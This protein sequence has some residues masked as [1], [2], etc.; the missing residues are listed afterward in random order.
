M[1]DK[2]GGRSFV[3]GSHLCLS[4]FMNQNGLVHLD[5]SGSA[6]TR[7]NGR[8]GK[9]FIEERIDRAIANLKWSTTF[10]RAVVLDLPTTTSDH[11]PI[12]LSRNAESFSH[13]KPFHF[14]NFW[15]RESASYHVVATVWR[16]S[17]VGS[18]AFRICRKVKAVKEALRKWNVT[19]FGIIQ[20]IAG[21]KEAN[22]GFTS[23]TSICR[24]SI[25]DFEFTGEV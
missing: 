20:G 7:N 15:T 2:N 3:A 18:P 22:S 6:Y 21:V 11:L 17:V 1:S 16:T 12:I 19:S 9:A 10:S 8:L 25:I 14:Q 24:I 23:T 4:N 5:F 13:P